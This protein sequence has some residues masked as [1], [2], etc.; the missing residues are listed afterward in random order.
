M[1]NFRRLAPW[2]LLGPVMGPLAEGVHRNIRARNPALASLYALAAIV[3][4]YNLATYG[5]NALATLHQMM[6]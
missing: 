4:W 2:L 1:S 3:S 5:G 6:F